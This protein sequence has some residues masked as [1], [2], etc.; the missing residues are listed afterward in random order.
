MRFFNKAPYVVKTA[1]N[2][3]ELSGIVSAYTGQ[4]S[5]VGTS[6]VDPAGLGLLANTAISNRPDQICDGNIAAAHQYGGSAQSAAQGLS[7][8]NTKCW[9]AVP[10]GVVRPG[11]TGRYTI[12]GPGFFNWD[13]SL[14]KN[15]ALTSS[16][17][18]KLQLRAETFNGLNWVNPSGFAST[19][20]TATNFGQISSFRAAR[21]M[22]LAAKIIF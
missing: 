16:E 2:G 17:R 10:Q 1:L 18:I 20:I 5:T 22:Q 21:R 7:W 9:A 13:A 8:F 12:W 4:P 3:W 14:Y 11:N 6:G 15:F 19:T